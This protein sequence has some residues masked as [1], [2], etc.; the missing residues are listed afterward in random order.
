MNNTLKAVI[1]AKIIGKFG[2]DFQH[3]FQFVL[4][5]KYGNLIQTLADSSDLGADCILKRNDGS[6]EK[7]YAVYAPESTKYNLSLFKTKFTDD[8]NTFKKKWGSHEIQWVPVCNRK[9]TGEAFQFLTN[10]AHPREIY[11]IKKIKDLIFETFDYSQI[12]KL[13][14]YLDIDSKFVDYNVLDIIISDII[15][16]KI[17]I[18]NDDFNQIPPKLMDKIKENFEE[19]YWE[20]KTKYFK[21]EYFNSIYIFK[22]Y[23]EKL[24]S[25]DQRVLKSKFQSTYEKYIKNPNFD[26]LIRNILN[27]LGQSHLNDD[28]YMYWLKIIIHY[29]FEICII[30][31][32]PTK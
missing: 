6:V 10:L 3:L 14:K 24:N 29:M 18:S 11:D 2:T 30:G 12:I 9:I 23:F 28:Y 7:I 25:N 15:S 8:Y 1:D 17:N 16:F 19:T 32:D 22:D 13:T 31:R 26:T 21:Q 5:Q 20:A 4:K 27:L